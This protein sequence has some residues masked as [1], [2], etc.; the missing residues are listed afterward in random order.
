MSSANPLASNDYD[1]RQSHLERGA[2]YDAGIAE[3]PWDDYL[4]RAEAH[5]LDRI[6]REVLPHPV[7]RALDFACGTGRIT[8][9]VEAHAFETWGVDVSPTMLERARARCLKTEFRQI[10]ITRSSL[11]TEP[12]DVVTA[13]RFFGNAQQD[14][15]TAALAALNGCLRPGGW[16]VID[17]HRNPRSLAPLVRRASGGANEMDLTHAKLRALLTVAGFRIVW[18]RPIGAWIYR[19]RLFQDGLRNRKP[20]GYPEK[21][22]QHSGLVPMSPAAVIVAR[23]VRELTPR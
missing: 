2:N 11:G 9:Q 10:D 7:G 4:A 22:F 1:Y 21:L 12:F 13:F 14:L 8:R 5:Q 17:N 16:L 19:D 3:S 15:R 6:F 18:Q 23:K 20:D